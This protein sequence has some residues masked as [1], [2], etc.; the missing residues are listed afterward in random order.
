VPTIDMRIDYHAAAMPGDLTARGKVIRFGGQFSTAEAQ[1]L[2]AG[3]KLLASGRGT[4]FRR[5]R[6]PDRRD[7]EFPESRRPDQTGSRLAKTAIIDLGGEVGPREISYARLDA[8][9]NGVA[10]ALLAR[11]L[12]RGERVAILSA[13]RAEYLA[14]YFWDHA[15]RPGSGA[16]Q[17]Q[18]P[19]QNHSF[20]HPGL[21][22][23][24]H[25]LRCRA[26]RRL[27]GRACTCVFWQP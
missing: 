21:R 8:M 20:H 16:D 26:P 6:K 14:A 23:Q 2:D 4:Y 3:G 11:G 13:N 25:L 18:V 9:A 19:R 1:V 17:L 27:S 24:A 12:A 10:R 15:G 7:G 5:R 22:R